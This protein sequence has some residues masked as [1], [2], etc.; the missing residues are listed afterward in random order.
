[1]LTT[2]IEWRNDQWLFE[3]GGLTPENVLEY[4][5]LSPFWDSSSNNAVLRMQTQFNQLS[6]ETKLKEMVGVEFTLASHQDNLF[7]IAKSKRLSPTRAIPQ[8]LYYIL[9]GN[10]YEC[11]NLYSLL[12]T[13][14]L[15]SI[16]QTQDAFR[17]ARSHAH[18]DPTLGYSYSHK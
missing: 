2:N 5:S 1:M 18:F 12:S 15:T 6:I 14:L 16:K 10:T 17:L 9:D 8:T 7:I 4:F 3:F 11:P 13:R